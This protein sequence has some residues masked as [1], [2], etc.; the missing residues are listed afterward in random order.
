MPTDE[1]RHLLKAFGVAVTTYED[2][3]LTKA[4]IDEVANAERD[5]RGRLQEVMALMD[6]LREETTRTR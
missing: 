2:A 3:V 6:H 5:A 1:T 4:P